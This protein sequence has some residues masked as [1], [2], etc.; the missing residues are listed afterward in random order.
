MRAVLQYER[1]ILSPIFLSISTVFSA[2]F[3]VPAHYCGCSNDATDV[4]CAETQTTDTAG[5][6]SYRIE[7]LQRHEPVVSAFKGW[8]GD[9]F[10]VHRG[11]I[12]LTIN[13]LRKLK[14][15]KRA[16]EVMEWVVRERPYK[17]DELDYSYLLE[18]TTKRHGIEQGWKLFTRVPV[19]FQNRLLY[20]N[21]V[22]ACLHKSAIRLGMDY[23]KKMRALSFPI[24][25]LVYNR[26]IVLHSS[27]GRRKTIPKIMARM[28]AD[29]VIPSSSTYNIL[30]KLE[31]SEHNIE[32]VMKVFNDMK[33][34]KVEPNEI[35]YCILATA[36]AVARL[37]AAC[38]A[39]IEAVEASKTGSNWSTFD[40]LLILYGYVGKEK[41]IERT[42]M[43]IESHQHVRTKSYVLAVE[44]F[45]RIGHIKRAEELWLEMKSK[46]VLKFTDQFNAIISVY[47]RYG[48]VDKASE[49][50]KEMISSNCK[51][52]SIT[53]RHLALG[54]LKAGLVEEALQTLGMA[55][56]HKSTKE[57]TR[58]TP[59][60]E[61]TLSI[62]E[63]LAAR[64]DVETT[65]KLFRELKEARYSRYT[66]VHN[67]LMRS[68]V[69]AKIYAPDFLR[70]MILGGARPDAETYSLLRLMAQFK[71]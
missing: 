9:G 36:H 18:F 53:Y 60:L 54:C 51:P 27:P 11:D 40:V 63:V 46:K 66:F 43:V 7:K 19:E 25:P 70:K 4:D 30:L 1:K 17:L 47:T 52:N 61:T 65:K 37:Y 5:C 50:F 55:C 21:L 22:L 62:I 23:M 2:R 12:F 8:M 14:M 58:S 29:G 28:K 71:T 26:L 56:D 41:E 42:W 67:T 15:N 44:A 57:V 10:P 48:L 64:G 39:Y 32:G 31:A 38:E 20:N 3:G 16:L 33:R 59:W 35:T 6:L 49:L 45:G 13:R 24:S 69:K 68:Y 34:A